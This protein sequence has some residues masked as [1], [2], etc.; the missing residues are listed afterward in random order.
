MIIVHVLLRVRFFV[1][2]NMVNNNKIFIFLFIIL[3]LIS[4]ILFFNSN[5]NVFLDKKEIN[6]NQKIIRGNSMEPNFFEGDKVNL[7][8]NYISIE[9]KNV[10]AFKFKNNDE[11]FIK[12][13]IAVSGDEVIFGKD[14]IIYINGEKLE[15]DYVKDKSFEKDNIGIILK[16]LNFY[17]NI[18]PKNKVFLLGDNRG[19]SYDSMSYGLVPIEYIV[20]KIE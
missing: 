7:T 16:Q 5:N 15:E 17:N 13:V 12:R 9:K 14:N 3:S 4:I 11:M 18:I 10:V 6:V 1:L 2:V 8:N 20:G 19:K